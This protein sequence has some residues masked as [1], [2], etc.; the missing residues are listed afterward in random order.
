MLIKQ[1]TFVIGFLS[2]VVFSIGMLFR[3]LHLP[4]ADMLAMIGVTG[5]LF[6]FL[7]LIFANRYKRAVSQVAS[8]RIK[9]RLGMISASVF[10]VATVF[11]LLHW[12]GAGIILGIS[13]L[14]FSFGFLP[15]LF[16]RMYKKSV[17]EV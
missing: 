9:W 17:E 11:E 8:E 3:L 6:L 10:G 2:S 12:P 5:L 4:G 13:F 7:P 14:L 16:F 1:L 15:F